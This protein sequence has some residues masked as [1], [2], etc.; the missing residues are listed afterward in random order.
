MWIFRGSLEEGGIVR[1]RMLLG[2]RLRG[3]EGVDDDA[4]M[5]TMHH[6]RRRLFIFL[7]IIV[8]TNGWLYQFLFLPLAG[9]L[10]FTTITMLLFDSTH[11][12]PTY[13]H[14]YQSAEFRTQGLKW[15]RLD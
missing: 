3:E 2:R 4:V 7:G 15:I 14:A 11:S 12:L 8:F 6:T 9:P 1:A 13:M 10:L 5:D